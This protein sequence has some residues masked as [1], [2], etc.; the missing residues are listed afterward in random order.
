MINRLLWMGCFSYVLTG[1]TIVIIGA[2]LPELLHH[3]SLSYS[4]GGVLVFAQFIGMLA[5][6]LSMPAISRRFGRKTAVILGHI[7]IGFEL[8]LSFL[9]AWQL[10]IVLAGMAGFGAGLVESSI[11][12]IIL[13]SIKH[14]QAVAM[15]KLEVAFGVGALTIPFIAS[16][17]IVKGLWMYSF[18]IL[19][20][21]SFMLAAGWWKLS[22]GEINRLLSERAGSGH[23][24]HTRPSYSKKGLTFLGICAFIFFLYSGSEVSIVH[25]F[26]SIYMEK[27]SIDSSM[28]AFTVTIYWL[29][30]VIGR[31]LCGV[32][33]EKLTYYRFLVF[34][35][36]GSVVVLLILPFSGQVWGGFVITFLLGLF[37]SGIFAIA[38]I[39]A[40]QA[41][42]GMTEQ[43]TSIMLASSGLG[44][45]LFPI[46]VGWIMDFFPAQAAFWLFIGV[47]AL[48]LALIIFSKKRRDSLV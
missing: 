45:A 22:F 41:L 30:M 37:M 11:G 23:S 12:T 15:S 17:L 47:M 36:V 40:N 4:D 32:L 6:V 42:P 8:I 29:A 5:G 35:V 19:G 10:V 18:L 1:V 39:F 43:T 24:K 31:L 44:G 34:S 13:L 38:L 33:A 21:C 3:Y 26:P 14:K 28:A 25:F 48:M 7:L 46:A 20:I 2:V 27:W 16:F 9:P